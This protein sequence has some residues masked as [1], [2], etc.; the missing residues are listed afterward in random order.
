M[1]DLLERRA[2]RKSLTIWIGPV[3]I[4]TALALNY[5]FERFSPLGWEDNLLQ[6]V[7]CFFLFSVGIVLSLG[8]FGRAP[9]KRLL[10][11]AFCVAFPLTIIYST[12]YVGMQFIQT[13]ADRLG[14]CQG[15]DSAVIASNVIPVSLALPGRAAEG[16]GVQRR[17]LFLS[18][19]NSLTVWGVLDP[20]DQQKILD[21]LAEYR[22]R[23]HGHPI[24]V[25]FFEKENWT[26]QQ[27]KH[28]PGM[29]RRGPEKLIRVANIG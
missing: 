25:M 28:G 24:R 7:L 19:Y 20:A 14:E 6:P 18:F 29:G 15:L 11:Y 27:G 4:A 17:G 3:L 22:H 12:F 13:G 5:R 23:T 16:C 21:S 1:I 8:G 9:I 26:V 10:L 2:T